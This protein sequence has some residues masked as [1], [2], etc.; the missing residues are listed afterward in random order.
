MGKFHIN[1]KGEPGLCRATRQCPFG[2]SED[3]YPSKEDARK[4]FEVKQSQLQE[5]TDYGVTRTT[6]FVVTD[7]VGSV[8]YRNIK[9]AEAHV[10]EHGGRIEP[11]TYVDDI[12]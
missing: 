1:A 9:S 8:R 3:H 5:K 4:A 7:S 12:Y 11:V 2:E 6:M 10:A